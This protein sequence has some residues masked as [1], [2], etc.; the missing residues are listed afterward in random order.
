MVL[1]DVFIDQD[2]PEKMYDITGLNAGGIASTA[3]TALGL[4]TV[5]RRQFDRGA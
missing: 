1:P 3:L 4:G 2:K 5:K